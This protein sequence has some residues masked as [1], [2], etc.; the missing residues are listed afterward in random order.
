M[1]RR[2]IT[3]LEW[4]AEGEHL[5]GSAVDRW[6]F[7]CPACGH[8]ATVQDW[9]DVGAPEAVGFSCIGRWYG[10][11]RRAFGEDRTKNADASGPCDYSGGGLFRVNPVVVIGELGEKER[12]YF[13]FAPHT[14]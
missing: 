7:V 9:W 12:H 1:G 14:L 2:R 10:G 8:V 11:S 13:D 3:I 6:R 5:F 4:L